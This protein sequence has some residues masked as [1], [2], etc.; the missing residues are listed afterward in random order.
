[1]SNEQLN[2]ALTFQFAYTLLIVITSRPAAG[3]S[4]G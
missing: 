3:R 1:M 2:V 4:A